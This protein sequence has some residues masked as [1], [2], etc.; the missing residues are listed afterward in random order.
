MAVLY[1]VRYEKVIDLTDSEADALLN[2]SQAVDDPLGQ[3]IVLLDFEDTN[4]DTEEFRKAV[5]LEV[6]KVIQTMQEFEK[7]VIGGD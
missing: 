7:F 2:N 3:R 4:P 6:F 1:K 5:S